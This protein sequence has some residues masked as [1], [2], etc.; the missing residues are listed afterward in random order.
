MVES[1]F[2]PAMGSSFRSSQVNFDR[3]HQQCERTRGQSSSAI[4]VQLWRR[5]DSQVL[6]LGNE[7]GSTLF[8]TDV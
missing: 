5:Q 2:L 8:V 4:P 7:Q 3:P 1:L 6:G